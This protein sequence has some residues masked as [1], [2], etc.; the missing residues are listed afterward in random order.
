MVS[1]CLKI[2]RTDIKGRISKGEPTHTCAN[3]R[4]RDRQT[5]TERERDRQTETER[6]RK[7]ENEKERK[8]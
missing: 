8:T 2:R 1:P 6:E 3:E 4:E 5:E 7:K